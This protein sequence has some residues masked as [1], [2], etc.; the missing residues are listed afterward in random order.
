MEAETER[1]DEIGE[2]EAE[3]KAYQ[4]KESKGEDKEEKDRKETKNKRV[5]VPEETCT[6]KYKK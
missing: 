5:Q 2:N 1:D 3:D 6:K 4:D